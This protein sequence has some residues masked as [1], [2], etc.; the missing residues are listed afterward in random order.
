MGT[1]IDYVRESVLTAPDELEQHALLEW[2]CGR[3]QIVASEHR[4]LEAIVREWWFSQT[5]AAQLLRELIFVD[6]RLG[7]LGAC[8][9]AQWA[10]DRYWRSEDNRPQIAI[11]TAVRWT[12]GEATEEECKFAGWEACNAAYALF[13]ASD[14]AARAGISASD[15]ANAVHLPADR[16][17]SPRTDRMEAASDVA[18]RAAEAAASTTDVA[19]DWDSAH[20]KALCELCEVVRAAVECPPTEVWLALD[21]TG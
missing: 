3:S 6:H 17:F 14:S 4:A 15:V 11:E 2:A 8:A 19:V 21:L 18:I 16:C 13:S 9:C 10:L 1:V 5:D 7:V 20:T 12:R